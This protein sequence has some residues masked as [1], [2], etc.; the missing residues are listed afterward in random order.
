M[1]SVASRP[2]PWRIGPRL[3]AAR[4]GRVVLLVGARRAEPVRRRSALVAAGCR[5]TRTSRTPRRRP[6]GE[7]AIFQV[8]VAGRAERCVG[9]RLEEQGAPAGRTPPAG[10]WGRLMRRPFQLLAGAIVASRPLCIDAHVLRQRIPA[11]RLWV[12]YSAARALSHR[13]GVRAR[14]PCNL[15]THHR[16]L[17]ASAASRQ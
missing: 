16:C 17:P 6:S 12:A 11:T 1:G 10:S 3:T 5:L 13:A 15:Y 8:T 9:R 14:L 2:G 7:C 4:S